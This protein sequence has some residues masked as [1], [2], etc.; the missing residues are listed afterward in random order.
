MEMIAEFSIKTLKL[1]RFWQTLPPPH[2]QG[3]ALNRPY[4]LLAAIVPIGPDYT[5]DILN[6]LPKSGMS[7]VV[8]FRTLAYWNK[9]N[10]W[11]L[12]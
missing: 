1:H 5:L 12:K 11:Q 8:P 4:I 2:P 3:Y 7:F 10:Y 6:L 9:C